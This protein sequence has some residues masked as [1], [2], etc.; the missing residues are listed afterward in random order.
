MSESPPIAFATSPDRPALE[1]RVNFGVFAGRDATPAELDELAR[2]LLAEVGEVS[3]VAE[4]RH[5][6]T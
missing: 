3:I 5:E 6:V 2:A 1:I 4:Q